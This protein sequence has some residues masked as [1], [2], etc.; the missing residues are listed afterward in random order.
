MS[1]NSSVSVI[2]TTFNRA[3]FLRESLTSVLTQSRPPL[4]VIV[5]DDG[6]TDDT[7]A[8]VQGFGRDVVYIRKDNGG[9]AAAINFALPRARGDYLWL[10][11]DDDV[12]LPEAIE[13]R[14]EV[15]QVRRELGWIFSSHYVGKTGLNGSIVRGAQMEVKALPESDLLYRLLLECFF[16]LQ[17]CLFHRTCFAKIGKLNESLLRSQDYEL[18]I[19]FALQFKFS[20]ITD[21]TFV[22]R[23]HDGVRGPLAAR[24]GVATRF[25]MWNKYDRIIGRQIREQLKLKDFAGDP[26]KTSQTDSVDSRFALIRRSAVMASK[27][28]ISEMMEDSLEASTMCGDRLSADERILCHRQMQFPNFWQSYVNDAPAFWR[29][30]RSLIRTRVGR[31]I[32]MFYFVGLLHHAKWGDKPLLERAHHV[33]MSLRILAYFFFFG[34]RYGY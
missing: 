8:V 28:L 19:R 18:L 27:G 9:K 29:G 21:P 23:L 1:L 15:L 7:P 25:Q 31:E 30:V 2:I 16:Y 34:W 4:E 24:H 13:R 5:V 14:L 33:V 20:G 26:H 32:L 11:D 17:S 12:A 6:S 3:G 10:F 22:L